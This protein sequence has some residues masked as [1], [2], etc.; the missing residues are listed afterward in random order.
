MTPLFSAA[1]QQTHGGRSGDKGGAHFS[2]LTSY[3]GALALTAWVL[4]YLKPSNGS[5]DFLVFYPAFTT[6]C[7]GRVGLIQATQCGLLLILFSISSSYFY[8]PFLD[9]FLVCFA[10]HKS[11]LLP[12][13][14][15]PASFLTSTVIWETF[16]YLHTRLNYTVQCLLEL[17][18]GLL[19][20][21]TC[22]LWGVSK[23]KEKKK[24]HA[25]GIYFLVPI[26]RNSFMTIDFPVRRCC[27]CPS[28]FSIITGCDGPLNCGNILCGDST[29]L[30]CLIFLH[31]GFCGLFIMQSA[32]SL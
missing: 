10:L 12:Y 31:V 25:L 22:V 27:M 16:H 24:D 8:F 30:Q 9:I 18:L 15:L 11:K 19:D 14:L 3:L 1:T 21:Q 13:G 5:L 32:F 4:W 29:I 26:K 6:V 20:M 17:Y 28:Q 7:R 23:K 2:A